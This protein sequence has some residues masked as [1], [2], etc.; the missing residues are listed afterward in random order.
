VLIDGRVAGALQ[1]GD[2]GTT[3]GGSPV[4]CAAAL[5]HMRL[6]AQGDL[7]AHVRAMGQRLAN[8]LRAIAREFPERFD[9]PRGVGLMLGLPVR[10]PYTAKAIVAAALEGRLLVNAA[11][12]NTLRFVPPLIIDAQEIDEGLRRFRRAVDGAT[13]ERAV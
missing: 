3:F 4:P 2:H 10:P 6:R 13:N 5:A 12:R 11:G 1:P 8:G 9:E 7:D